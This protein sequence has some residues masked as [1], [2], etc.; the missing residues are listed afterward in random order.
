MSQATQ[1]MIT[2]PREMTDAY[3]KM[4]ITLMDRQASREISTSEVFGQCLQF[5]PTV[6]DKLRLLRFAGEEVRHFKAIADLMAELGVDIDAY[7]K[8]RL[9]AG[10]RFTH[11]PANEQIHDWIEATL[12][13]FFIDRAATFQLS[14]Y[15][16]GTYEPLARANRSIVAEEEG[17]QNFGEACLL[18]LCKDPA[19]RAQ[20]QARLKTW[21]VGA[22]RIFGRAGTPG[23]RY[24]LEVGLKTRD[25]GEIAAAWLDDVRP[26]LK[27]A[28]LRLPRR[29]ELDIDVPPQC[30]LSMG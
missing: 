27:R 22:M 26:V 6:E 18:E 23:N 7:L 30:N 16:K 20:F 1:K 25:S 21:F 17:H 9:P 14:E 28:G 12:F 24:C 19:V 3:R 15:V 2:K 8:N 10:S 13:N 5:A 29:E 4:V 11:D